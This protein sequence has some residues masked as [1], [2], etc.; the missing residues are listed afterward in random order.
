[1]A[2]PLA[3]DPVS[4]RMTLLLGIVA[5]LALPAMWMFWSVPAIRGV[6]GGIGCVAAAVGAGAGVWS[7]ARL[8]S[9]RHVLAT[10][11]AVIAVFA[12]AWSIRQSLQFVSG[13][14]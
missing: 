8:H 5:L 10:L 11:P 1:M 2:D 9:G 6:C 14:H 12:W 7:S 4:L 13:Q 3:V